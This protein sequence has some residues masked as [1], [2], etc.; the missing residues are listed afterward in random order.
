MDGVM[1]KVEVKV[2]VVSGGDGKVVV[3]SME[4]QF[5]HQALFIHP[6]NQSFIHSFI[7]SAHPGARLHASLKVSAAGAW[8][9]RSVRSMYGPMGSRTTLGACGAQEVV[10]YSIGE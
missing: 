4:N 10:W 3:E 8:C 6:F 1:V 7:S 2:M 9:R 5:K